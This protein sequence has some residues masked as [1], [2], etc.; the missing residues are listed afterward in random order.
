VTGTGRRRWLGAAAASAVLLLAGCGGDGDAKP[1][2]LLDGSALPAL[3][4]ALSDGDAAVMT[5]V[6]DLPATD[7]RAVACVTG[8]GVGSPDVVVERIGADGRSVTFA[9]GARVFACDAAEGAREGSAA[10]CGGAFGRR[11]KG[12]LTDPR[13]ELA[14]CTDAH[15]ETVAF[16]W[17]EPEPEAAYVAADRDGWVEVYAT[18]RGLPVRVST[19]EGIG[20]GTSSLSLTVTQYAGDGSQ[21]RE[22]DIEAK[23]AG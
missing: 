16:V 9:R 10:S 2:R 14:N 17:I 18:R 8:F 13:L 12:R 1:T 22:E 15:G 3:P 20:A 5:I 23:V 21:L 4:S 19:T 6:H 11:E 7:E